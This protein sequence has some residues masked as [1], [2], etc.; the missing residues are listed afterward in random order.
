MIA[1]APASVP[2]LPTDVPLVSGSSS[3]LNAM[4]QTT[5]HILQPGV[6]AFLL[7]KDMC[8]SRLLG[9]SGSN[10]C[11]LIAVLTGFNFLK[12]SLDFSVVDPI[13]FPQVEFVEI[14][15]QGNDLYDIQTGDQA[16]YFDTEEAMQICALTNFI[17][18]DLTVVTDD[19]QV[20]GLCR[21]W[22]IQGGAYVCILQPGYT[23]VVLSKRNTALVLFDSHGQ[24]PT[25]GA[26]M[27]GSSDPQAF[28]ACLLRF[29]ANMNNGQSG[30]IGA[31]ISSLT[32]IK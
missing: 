4:T 1:Q 12:D 7:P 28:S 24:G 16:R 30:F 11:T 21:D 22:I 20:L 26:M 8:Q 29:A 17:T 27:F 5:V 25:R 18:A 32:L 9:R 6:L 15:R 19:Q 2:T 23:V 14:M 10:A 13:K 3:T 31:H